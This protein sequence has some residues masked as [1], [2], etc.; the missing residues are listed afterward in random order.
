MRPS[1]LYCAAKHISQAVILVGEA[2]QGYPQHW[3]LAL[4]HLAEAGDELIQDHPELAAKVREERKALEARAVSQ[5]GEANALMDLL[6]SVTAWFYPSPSDEVISTSTTA[7]IPIAV[8]APV[9]VERITPGQPRTSSHPVFTVIDRSGTRTVTPAPPTPSAAT[10]P[11]ASPPVKLHYIEE[12]KSLDHVH[13]GDAWVRVSGQLNYR[14]AD[15]DV[16][17]GMIGRIVNEV[18]PLQE[19]MVQAL[20][21]KYLS[22]PNIAP[23]KP[24][25]PPCEAKRKAIEAAQ[26]A[27]ADA[28]AA[29]EAARANPGQAAAEL[30]LEEGNR[31]AEETM[32]QLVTESPVA[33]LA[34][35]T[36]W[37]PE[38]QK[39]TRRGPRPFADSPVDVKAL[40]KELQALANSPEFKAI[41]NY[42][43]KVDM[44]KDACKG[45]SEVVVILT[46]LANFDPAYSL[47]TCIKDQACAIATTGRRVLVLVHIG[48]DYDSSEFHENVRIVPIVPH[49]PW[50]ENV[51]VPELAD[52]WYKFLLALANNLW[53]AEVKVVDVI[54]H[55]LLFQEWYVSAA[56]AIH[57]AGPE[58]DAQPAVAFH[59]YHMAHS[60][61]GTRPQ[62][63]EDP[64]R[65]EYWRTRLPT[66]HKLVILADSDASWFRGYYIRADNSPLQ[67]SDVVVIRN[68]RDPR[69]FL[70]FPPRIQKLV[71][72]YPRVLEGRTC[73]L[74]F[75][76]TRAND[77]GVRKVIEFLGVMGNLM[78]GTRP[79]L[80]LAAAHANAPEQ[81]AE[82]DRLAAHAE[83]FRMEWGVDV[84]FT[85]DLFPEVAAKGMDADE[86]RALWS[87]ADLFVFPTISEAGSLVLLEAMA[88]RCVLVLN[89]SVAA[90]RSYAPMAETVWVP[91]GSQK[92]PGVADFGQLQAAAQ[93]AFIRL[94]EDGGGEWR[95]GTWEEMGNDW[96]TV[97]VSRGGIAPAAAPAADSSPAGQGVVSS[98][99]PAP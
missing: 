10:P 65:G 92:E 20:V 42:D 3:Y 78:G 95:S 75:S 12:G 51:V 70:R 72:K 62:S 83:K 63:A 91:W 13:V 45:E 30:M 71:T 50:K 21:T 56:A 59:W 26:K 8:D 36:S 34:V 1:C 29:E 67:E 7:H 84:L 31:A 24:G 99:T 22:L 32:R 40:G 87:I 93:A 23:G 61:C 69:T 5:R 73:L 98:P 77:K 49:S 47:S 18:H 52:K 25:C 44:I 85:P 14:T 9:V 68:I 58:I 55:D 57:R 60:S 82:R 2:L 4:G 64:Q 41:Q 74:P 66:G 53:A 90:F 76:M 33:E 19:K 86:M 16:P 54:A 6:D 38:D 96:H 46:T 88:S 27:L 11:E 17:I 81:K 43:P 37:N 79:L 80:I 28:K 89:S 94:Q 15:R 39:P 97:L 48:A 35:T